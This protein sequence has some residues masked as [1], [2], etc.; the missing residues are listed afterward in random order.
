MDGFPAKYLFD[1]TIGYSYDDIIL[2]PGY[3]DFRLDDIS[4][5]THI[6]KNI[7]INYPFISSPM[8]TVTESKMAITMALMGGIGILHNNNTIEEQIM[9]LRYAFHAFDVNGSGYIE[10]DELKNGLKNLGWNVSQKGIDHIMKVT[11]SKDDRLDFEE[12]VAANATLWK[13]DMVSFTWSCSKTFEF[14]KIMKFEF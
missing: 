14:F 7:K 10:L 1:Q 11:E 2:L 4:L 12:F 3:I 5:E 8:D 13:N 6:T 9:E